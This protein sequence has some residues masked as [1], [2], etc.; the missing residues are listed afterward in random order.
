MQDKQAGTAPRK[1]GVS[2]AKWGYIFCIPFI[3]AFLIFSLYPIIY[4]ATISFSDLKGMGTNAFNFLS[5]AEFFDNYI[6]ILHNGK[7]QLA[8][9]TTFLLWTCNFI[10]QIS[11]ALLLTAWFTNT[12]LKIRAQ[13]AF[14][15]LVFMPNI[16][17]A[18]AIAVLFYSFFAYPIGPVNTFLVDMGLITEPVEFLRSPAVSRGIISF[19]QFWMWY[20][21]TMVVLIA[22]VM[23]I[24]PTLYE[25][26]AIDGASNSKAFFHITIP[27]LRTILL[28]IL[29][30]SMI[31]GLQM[32]DIPKLFNNGRPNDTTGTVAVYIY[33]QAFT[34]GYQFNRAATA[35]MILFIITAI[36]AGVLFFVMRDRDAARERK[37]KRTLLTAHKKASGRVE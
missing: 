5:P 28:Y 24:N 30:T 29:V 6:D 21:N 3:V 32:F 19:I 11:L 35:S 34:G 18:G 23:G 4:T 37:A 33:N 14:K 26:A 1:R 22:G 13:G 36:L 17:T 15:T 10:P 25:A 31:G 8:L 2:Y 27:C 9:R 7:F 16:I 12:S 20:G